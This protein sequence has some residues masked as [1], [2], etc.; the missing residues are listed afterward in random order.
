MHCL[1][2]CQ[3][4]LLNAKLSIPPCSVL[5]PGPFIFG[6]NCWS[7]LPAL[8]QSGPSSFTISIIDTSGFETYICSN[9]IATLFAHY[10]AG[11]YLLPL[12]LPCHYCSTGCLWA[13]LE[14][15]PH[16]LHHLF[17]SFGNRS[18]LLV[19]KSCYMPSSLCI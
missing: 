15:L 4:Y 7:L 10:Y 18:T 16:L 9:G 2:F 5:L 19:S 12:V 14:A 13:Y 8:P 6:L 17:T 11:M 1:H 3:L